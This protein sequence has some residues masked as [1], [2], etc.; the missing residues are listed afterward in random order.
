MYVRSLLVGQLQKAARDLSLEGAAAQTQQDAIT[1]AVRSAV[2]S[3]VPAATVTV[4]PKSYHDYSNVASPA[5]E[6]NDADHDGVCNHGE[7]FVDMNRNG[8][9]DADGGTNDRGGAKDVVLLIATVSYDRMPLGRM[10]AASP[11]MTLIAKTMIRNQPNDTQAD[12]PTA[13]CS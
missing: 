1:A 11:R 4:V 8:H 10:F 6:Y 9:W 7:A 2:R 3:V 13:L 5:E 12:P